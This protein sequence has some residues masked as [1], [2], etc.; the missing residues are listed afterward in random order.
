MSFFFLVIYINIARITS[1]SF[2]LYDF[3]FDHNTTENVAV[4]SDSNTINCNIT[5]HESKIDCGF[6]GITEEEC[7]YRGCCWK[8][9]SPNPNNYPYCYHTNTITNRTTQIGW[10]KIT[11]CIES[12]S[13]AAFTYYYNNT[14]RQLLAQYAITIKIVPPEG[15]NNPNYNTYAVTAVPC[16]NPIYALNNYKEL[17]FV[18]DMDGTFNIRS[19]ANYENNWLGTTTAINRLRNSCYVANSNP[20]STAR[21]FNTAI[22][23]A[24]CVSANM[25]ILPKNDGNSAQC[26]WNYQN[27]VGENMEVYFGFDINKMYYCNRS[28]LSPTTD[29]TIEPTII[30]TYIPTM[31]PTTVPTYIPTTIKPSVNPTLYPTS[32][33]PSKT[34]T[35]EK[36]VG[37]ISSTLFNTLFGKDIGIS[38]NKGDNDYLMIYILIAV[39]VGLI[40]LICVAVFLCCKKRKQHGINMTNVKQIQSV[41]MDSPVAITTIN[42]DVGENV[43]MDSDNVITDRINDTVEMQNISQNVLDEG[44]SDDTNGNENDLMYVTGDVNTK[45]NIKETPKE[46]DEE[47]NT[48][49]NE[50]DGNVTDANEDDQ[51]DNEYDELYI[52][53]SKTTTS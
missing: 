36:S 35:S 9:I 40:V 53:P 24:H 18:I 20:I 29:P 5:S 4:T 3:T 39:I 28:T 45:G 16:S 50:I 14:I 1:Q 22:Y 43:N 23:G 19:L 44:D 15:I 52:I 13:N 34:P 32:M 12:A 51:N 37:E 2:P 26:E 38:I 46:K 6:L 8:E 21:G 33:N 10:I 42:M 11:S 48:I 7:I 25:H 27:L 41:S 17:S 30:P 47:I 31:N 49:G